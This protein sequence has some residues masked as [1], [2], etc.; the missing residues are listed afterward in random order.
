MTKLTVQELERIYELTFKYGWLEAEERQEGWLQDTAYQEKARIEGELGPLINSALD[1]MVGIYEWWLENHQKDGWIET[2]KQAFF[3][4]PEDL[5]FLI[6]NFENWGE[7]TNAV[8]VITSEIERNNP[9]IDEDLF[10]Y[11]LS[12]DDNGIAYIFFLLEEYYDTIVANADKIL[13][14]LYNVWAKAFGVLEA[15]P[16]VQ[17]GYEDVQSAVGSSLSERIVG[18]Q[19]GL[20]TAHS[21]GTMADHLIEGADRPGSGKEILDHLSSGPHLA[22][23]TQD[24]TSVLGYTPGMGQMYEDKP[25]YY[26]PELGRHLGKALEML[27]KMEKTAIFNRFWGLLIGP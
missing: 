4:D 26:E 15:Y 18:F 9:T 3:G 7:F 20:N 19:I 2:M 23:W 22:D 14:K 6:I 8:Y 12:T 5:Q 27:A 13:G 17:Q 11:A 25:T 1:K 21:T 24:L 10:T 16:K